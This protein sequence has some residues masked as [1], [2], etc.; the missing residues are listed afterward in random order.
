MMV[1]ALCFAFML[2]HLPQ[3]NAFQ[4]R[5]GIRPLMPRSPLK[6]AHISPLPWVPSRASITSASSITANTSLQMSFD[7]DN[8]QGSNILASLIV[9]GIL[10][11]FVVSGVA[12]MVQ[13]ATSPNTVDVNLG[14]AV[15][16]RQDNARYAAQQRQGQVPETSQYER[17]SRAKIQE[18]LNRV[19]VFYLV[20][21]NGQMKSHIY[22]SYGDAVKTKTESVT[23]KCTTLDQVL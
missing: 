5:L 2:I 15:A 1:K 4:T 6:H 8:Q 22:L 7:D 16:T 9:I 20:D 13:L 10:A 11:I 3:M 18:K 23:V 14:D 19:P 21:G 12:P 17:L